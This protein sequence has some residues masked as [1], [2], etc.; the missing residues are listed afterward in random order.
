V[1]HGWDGLGSIFL[2]PYAASRQGRGG[3]KG[4]IR[5]RKRV[6]DCIYG[7]LYAY[8]QRGRVGN[9]DFCEIG[10]LLITDL[11]STGL[12]RLIKLLSLEFIFI[13]KL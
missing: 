10:P 11:H 13:T 4:G 2:L 1:Q 9:M 7:S 3:R 5:E 8:C 6:P 12:G